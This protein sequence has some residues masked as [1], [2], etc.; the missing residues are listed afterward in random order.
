MKKYLYALLAVA[1]TLS[2]ASCNETIEENGSDYPTVGSNTLA[3]TLKKSDIDTR[4]G[5]GVPS[6]VRDAM[7]LGDPID[8][9]QF[10]LTETVTS[11]DNLYYVEP[12]TK[13]TPVYTENFA[14]ISGGSFKGLAFKV[15]QDGMTGRG[16]LASAAFI[17]DGE[18]EYNGKNWKREFTTGPWGD[19]EALLF[20]AR[21][22]TEDTDPSHSSQ[23]IG[24]VPNSHRYLYEG[25]VQSMTFSYRS[26]LTAQKQ[27]DILFAARTITKTGETPFPILFYHALTG[28]KFATA[29][30]NGA[31]D[32]VKTFIKKVEFTGLLGYGKC[33]VTSLTEN[34]GYVDNAASYSSA[35]AISWDA[36][37]NGVNGQDAVYSQVF[38]E[39]TVNYGGGTSGGSFSSK[40]DYPGSFSTAG[41]TNNLN[42]GDASMTFWFVPQTLSDDVKVKITFE[43]EVKVNGE[44]RRT[45]YTR[46]LDFGTLLENVTWLPGQLRTYTLKS[47]EVDVDIHDQVSGFK[48]DKVEIRN[49]GNVDAFIR[50]M[51]VAN[52]WGFAGNEEGVAMG[53]VDDQGS[54]Y[55]APWSMSWNATASKYVDN[56]GGEFTGLPVPGATSDWVLATDG[57]FYYTKAVPPGKL[58]GEPEAAK[59]LFNEYN[60]DT[61]A[62]PVPQI[63]YLDGSVKP[64][65]KVYLKMEIPVQAIEAKEDVDWDAAWAAVLGA[66][67][68]PVPVTE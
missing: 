8:G 54:A 48:K 9:Q 62:H 14:N 63:Y 33:T 52:W 31:N 23:P 11:L 5:S 30:T 66:S 64:Y 18:F 15:G 29:H 40:G 56:Y 41:N 50:A 3:F 13:G 58:T 46:D 12:E 21:M 38:S 42:D 45:E 19:E 17:S 49:T 1:A 6:T 53:Y 16:A 22:A 2:F 10:Y 43:I 59:P 57:Y 39:T 67:N 65:T 37:F 32:I 4:S 61:Q 27:Q 24:I 34:D 55:V 44:T 20:Y 28:V 47:E 26:P 36:S 51:I 7:P 35:N 68:K 60:L 25:N